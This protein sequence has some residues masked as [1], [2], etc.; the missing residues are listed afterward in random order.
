MPAHLLRFR[1]VNKD[2]FEALK[3]G[4]KKV[5]TRAGT[6]KNTKIKVG[7]TLKFVCGKN[8]FEKDVAKV[9]HFKNIKALLKTYKP[10][11]INPNL[12]TEGETI[13]MYYSYPNYREKIKKYG[14]VAFRL[15]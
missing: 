3:S 10:K 14:L 11:D 7:D 1:A 12:R 6:V 9:E 5:E 2:T 13:D 8:S 15:K 4:S